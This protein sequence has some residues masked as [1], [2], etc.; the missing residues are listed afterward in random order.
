[1]TGVLTR[2]K[3]RDHTQ[4]KGPLKTQKDSGHLPNRGRGLGR[5]QP[6]LHLDLGLP[7]SKM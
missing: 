6:C 1:M 5:K 3:D 2:G 4:S 7:A